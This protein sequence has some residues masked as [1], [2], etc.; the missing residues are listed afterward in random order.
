MTVCAS[1]N[2]KLITV[3]QAEAEETESLYRE[4]IAA[5]RK[6]LS[7]EPRTRWICRNRGAE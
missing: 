5:F 4:A 2:Y 1:V 7:R 6:R 3:C